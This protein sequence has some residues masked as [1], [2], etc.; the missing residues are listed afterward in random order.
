MFGGFV[1]LPAQNWIDINIHSAYTCTAYAALRKSCQNEKFVLSLDH[2]DHGDHG[3]HSS[4]F[5]KKLDIYLK[6]PAINLGR[7]TPQ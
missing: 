2:G 5:N 4:L 3:D 6:H 1:T 7:N